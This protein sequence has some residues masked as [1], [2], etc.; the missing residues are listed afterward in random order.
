[1]TRPVMVDTQ[2]IADLRAAGMPYS[3]IARHARCTKSTAHYWCNQLQVAPPDIKDVHAC[4][5][6]KAVEMGY[7][8]LVTALAD[9]ASNATCTALAELFG[10]K[11][12]TMYSWL[13]RHQIR[14]GVPVERSDLER[15]DKPQ[16]LAGA[17]L[18]RWQEMGDQV[19]V[20]LDW[21]SGQAEPSLTY[22]PIRLAVGE[23][24]CRECGGVLWGS[25]KDC[26]RCSST[27][28]IDPRLVLQPGEWEVVT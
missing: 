4:A 8:D 11:F 21:P 15:D 3:E 10:V 25:D 1:M 17:E 19:P 6:T 23:R 13:R 9:L 26:P 18:E 5:T 20:P 24:W 22:R 2:Q 16:E 14:A 28:V 12:Q 27:D 7:P